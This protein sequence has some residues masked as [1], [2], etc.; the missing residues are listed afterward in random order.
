MPPNGD[1][2]CGGTGHLGEDLALR[3]KYGVNAQKRVADLF[4][5]IELIKK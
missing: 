2:I 1:V 5:L 3:K 4:Y